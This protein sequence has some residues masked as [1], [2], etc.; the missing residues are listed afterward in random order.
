[1]VN[2]T[3]LDAITS[4]TCTAHQMWLITK[5]LYEIIHISIS[6]SRYLSSFG[7]VNQAESL[8][9]YGFFYNTFLRYFGTKYL[10][11]QRENAQD[12]NRCEEIQNNY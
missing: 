3:S 8:N 5:N 12:K 2:C 10:L 4:K 11:E 9:L 6:V 1:M 7:K